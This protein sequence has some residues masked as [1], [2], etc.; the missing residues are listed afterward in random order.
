MEDG[1]VKKVLQ[2]ILLLSRSEACQLVFF[3]KFWGEGRD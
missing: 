2:S 1:N 3:L